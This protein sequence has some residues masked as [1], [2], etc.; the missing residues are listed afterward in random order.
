[1]PFISKTNIVSVWNVMDA[2][3]SE[4]VS[5][6]MSDENVCWGGETMKKS[7]F[8]VHNV[9]GLWMT[10]KCSVWTNQTIA[11]WWLSSFWMVLFQLFFILLFP[12]FFTLI[13]TFLMICK[14]IRIEIKVR[15]HIKSFTLK[16][17]ELITG[18]TAITIGS[19]EN[20]RSMPSLYQRSL[21]RIFKYTEKFV[22]GHNIEISHDNKIASF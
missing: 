4:W 6:W 1:M 11:F 22:S 21:W 3:A 9:I 7:P 14:R 16:A 13:F 10:N 20:N 19:N 17:Y 5:E 12:P 8:T 18:K 2:W 15:R